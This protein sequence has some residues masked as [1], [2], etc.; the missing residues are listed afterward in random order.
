MNNPKIHLGPESHID[1]NP[2][3]DDG[4]YDVFK[5]GNLPWCDERVIWAVENGAQGPIRDW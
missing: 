2:T 1:P 3:F 4:L 5:Y